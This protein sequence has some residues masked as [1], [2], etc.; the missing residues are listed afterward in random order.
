VAGKA[1][2]CKFFEGGFPMLKTWPV[3]FKDFVINRT[4]ELDK[5][6]SRD[7]EYV[8]RQEK[9]SRVI[10]QLLVGLGPEATELFMEYES[11]EGGMEGCKGD[12][13][14]RQGLI[15]GLQLRYRIAR[16][17]QRS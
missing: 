10:N 6:L 5:I 17:R 4:I 9:F 2:A 12:L 15:D 16:I 3:I 13:L 14:Y 1:R 7:R 11:T 8:R